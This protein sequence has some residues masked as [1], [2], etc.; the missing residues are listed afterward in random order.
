MKI[1][2]AM[3]IIG[4]FITISLLLIIISVSSLINLN[5]VGSAV[6]EVNRVAVPTLSSS[7][8]LKASF[9]NMSRV[10]FE[11]YIEEQVTGL[12]NKYAR[13]TDSKA[14]FDAELKALNSVLSDDS[15]MQSSLTGVRESY[16]EYVTNVEAM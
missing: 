10:T 15:A 16:N 5:S 9:L 4:G 6:D 7:N 2:V 14:D 8:S 12:E 3:R 11:A 13:F 1:T